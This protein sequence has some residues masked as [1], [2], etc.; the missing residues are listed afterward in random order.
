VPCHPDNMPL[1][2]QAR[3]APDH[4]LRQAGPR[5]AGAMSGSRAGCLGNGRGAGVEGR[6]TEVE[7]VVHAQNQRTRRC[8]IPRRLLGLQPGNRGDGGEDQDTKV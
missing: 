5:S 2:F 3:R 1:G 4:R 6:G 8:A 7:L